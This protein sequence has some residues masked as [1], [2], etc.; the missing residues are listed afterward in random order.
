MGEGAI[1]KYY[2]SDDLLLN[3]VTTKNFMEPLC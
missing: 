3:W 1:T 2:L